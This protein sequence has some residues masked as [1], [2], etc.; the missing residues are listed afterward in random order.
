MTGQNSFDGIING[1]YCGQ[2]LVGDYSSDLKKHVAAYISCYQAFDKTGNP[3]ISYISAWKEGENEIW[4][5][6][7]SRQFTKLLGCKP[8]EVALIFRDSIVDRRIYKYQGMDEDI[9]REIRSKKE[10]DGKRKRLREDV[11]EKGV[12]DAVY[13]ISLNNENVMWLKDLATVETHEQ[14]NIHISL[15]CLTAVTKEM[16]AEEERLKREKLQVLLE[17]AGAVC[18]ELNQ[19]MQAISSY[20]ELFLT[21][22]SEN[23]PL[24]EKTEAIREQIQRMGRI[25]Q[26]VMRITRYETM[27]YVDDV[28]IIDIDKASHE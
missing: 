17:M 8:S 23:N 19:P 7:V 20:A 13:K 1:D 4:Y 28:Q 24:Y 3:A 18:H 2:I 11:T 5:E 16:R 6:F 21:G 14:D 27:D 15:G 22:I 25:T 10:L 12:T 9:E 26:K